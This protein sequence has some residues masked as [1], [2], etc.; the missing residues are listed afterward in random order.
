MYQPHYWYHGNYDMPTEKL[1]DIFSLI[2]NTPVKDLQDDGKNHLTTYFSND[3]C[4]SSF[5]TKYYNEMGTQIMKNVGLYSTTKFEVSYWSQIYSK[6][7]SHDYHKHTS[8]G[9]YG[10]EELSAILSWVHFVKVPEQKCFKFT[11]EKGENSFYP[12]EQNSGDIIYF[13]SWAYHGVDPNRTND[14]RVVIAGNI[15]VTENDDDDY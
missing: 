10:E 14:L 12:D 13:P 11:D 2:N 4:L 5:F 8:F 1:D 7:M 9:L 15:T 3:D 6:C